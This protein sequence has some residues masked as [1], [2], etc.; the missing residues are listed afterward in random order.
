MATDKA[1]L[2]SLISSSLP[3]A[4]G[5]AASDI[6]GVL[7]EMVDSDVNTSESTEQ[8]VSG[9]IDMAGSFLKNL[10][11]DIQYQLVL[12]GIS[13]LSPQAPPG[14]DS[15]IRVEFGSSQAIS[16]ISIDSGGLMTVQAGGSGHYLFS[17]TLNVGRTGAAGVSNIFMRA[18]V[19]SVQAGISRFVQLD[20]ANTKIEV[21]YDAPAFLSAGDE[22][23]MQFLRDSSG[24]NSGELA[25]HFATPGGW[26]VAPSARVRIWRITMADEVV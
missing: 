7:N 21:Q 12:E 13:A 4:S 15:P 20:N 22:F 19:N 24:N 5:I 2:L 26:N 1:G 25:E 14:V 6:R 10:P 23:D 18:R 3:D 16:P 8:T 11:N 17:V 9:G